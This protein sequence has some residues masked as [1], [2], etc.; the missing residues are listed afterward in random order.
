MCVCV[1]VS[2]GPL[3]KILNISGGPNIQTLGRWVIF[4]WPSYPTALA[5]PRI[6]SKKPPLVNVS[7]RILICATVL[8]QS[9]GPQPR[10]Q[11]GPQTGPRRRRA[12]RLPMAEST[13]GPLWNHLKWGNLGTLGD[14]D[15]R[16]AQTND[17]DY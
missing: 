15:L 3:L 1:C 17:L 2:S 10:T 9:G 4:W 8:A 13:E 11:A 14:L 16:F 6:I 7:S 12:T 5:Y